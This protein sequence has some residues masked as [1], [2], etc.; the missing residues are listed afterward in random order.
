MKQDKSRLYGGVAAAVIL[1]GL[2]GFSLAKL[3]DGKPVTA[4]AAAAEAE[5]EEG[6][7]GVVVME[8]GAIQATGIVVQPVSAGGFAGEILTQGT[9]AATPGGEAVLTA[10]AAGAVTRIYKRLG[11]PVRAGEALA[12]V[13]SREAA[14]IAADRSVA[15]AR[16][17]LAQTTLARE[18]RLFEQRVSARQDYEQAQAEAAAAN[19]EARRAQ[20]AA[21]AANVTADGRGVIVASPISGQ[22]TASTANLG[23]F[24]QPETELFR[25]ADPKLIQVEASIAD[26]DAPR[27][28]PGDRAVIETAD[29]RAIE[30]KVRSIT[31]GLN[32]ETRAATAV[33]DVSP[34]GLQPGQSVRARIIPGV[35]SGSKAIVVPDEAVQSVEGHDVVFVRTAAGF[36]ARPVTVG[37][38]SAGR[39]EIVSGLAAGQVI[40]ARNAFLL[41]AELGKGEGEGH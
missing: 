4:V 40:A 32:A 11:D 22:I 17:T 31:P 14:Q 20:V 29:G 12:V 15:A 27:I 41:K 26:M 37:Q 36:E 8:A 19:A 21:G 13:E 9:V 35:A 3:S 2:G 10:R 25:I 6:E 18:R 1:A 24:V 23:A 33:L 7:P 34:D 38:R 30:G 28:K 16:A 39:A 5:H